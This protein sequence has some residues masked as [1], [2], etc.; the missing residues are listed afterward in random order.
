MSVNQIIESALRNMVT[1]IWPLVCPEEKPPKEYIVYNP[2]IDVPE[3]YGDNAAGEW[4]QYMQ[5]H[6]FTKSN[7]L[8]KRKEIRKALKDAGFLVSDITTMY[9]KDS[10]YYHL[11]FSCNIEENMED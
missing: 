1:S 3:D 2:E 8:K 10:G 7:Y 4:V 9:E 11:C 5:V 6:L